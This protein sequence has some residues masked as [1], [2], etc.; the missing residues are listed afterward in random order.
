[1]ITDRDLK[2]R[3]T[4]HRPDEHKTARCQIIRE[5]AHTFADLMRDHVPDGRELSLALTKLE[6]VVMWANAGI[7]RHGSE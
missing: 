7:V 5:T 1:M 2:I 3:F 6:E 4:Y